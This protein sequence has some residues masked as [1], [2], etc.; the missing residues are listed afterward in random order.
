MY[1][2]YREVVYQV[3]SRCIE[4]KTIFVTSPLFDSLE[5][6]EKY[7]STAFTP[8]GGIYIR[9]SKNP[10]AAWT[11][12]ITKWTHGIAKEIPFHVKGDQDV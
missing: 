8:E 9:N 1:Q 7:I 4:N 5:Q 10:D 12:G 3:T 2:T 11:H 6:A